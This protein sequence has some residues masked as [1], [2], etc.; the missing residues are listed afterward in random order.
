[1]GLKILQ[2]WIFQNLYA[3]QRERFA[4]QEGKLLN[5]QEKEMQQE[6]ARLETQL[7]MLEAELE[8]VQQG[9]RDAAKQWKPEFVA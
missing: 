5:Q 4:K 7:K 9:E 1:M 6:K 2:N 3:Q 8:G